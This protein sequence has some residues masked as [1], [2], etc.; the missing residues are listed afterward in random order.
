MKEFFQLDESVTYL[1][2][3]YMSPTLKTVENAGIEGLQRKRN[4]FRVTPNDFF[5][6]VKILQQEYNQLINAQ[7]AERIVVMPSVSYGLATVANNVNLQKNEQ[8]IVVHEQFPSNYYTWVKLAEKNHAEVVTVKPPNTTKNRGKIW[9][10]RILEAINKNTKIVA[11]SHVHW[12]DGTKFDL[13]AIRVRTREVGALLIIDG[14]QSVGALTFDVQS[15]QPDA[16]ICAGYKWLLGPY[17][18]ALGYYGAAFDDGNP[19]EESWINRFGSE[20]FTNLV[21]YQS[22]Y[23]D[24]ASRYQVGQSGNFINVPMMTEALRMLNYWGTDNIQH[25]CYEI[26]K[27]AIEV[28][29]ESGFWIED[30]A[31]RSSHL[32][33]IRLPKHLEIESI[34]NKLAAAQIMVS[35]RGDAI[36]ISPNVYND[37]RD[38]E[39][40]VNI[41]TS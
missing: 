32:F 19:I 15:I 39:N 29:Q 2:G 18:M 26:T 10:E 5:S 22:N 17:S 40:L 11:I 35:I 3:A 23:K 1:N 13:E 14:T 9:N 6:G 25:Y 12:A 8:I 31:Y 24:G 33:G 30:L 28:L 36:R 21:N 41:L 27:N 34:K 4:P 16:L 38:L 37:V 20:N 7:E